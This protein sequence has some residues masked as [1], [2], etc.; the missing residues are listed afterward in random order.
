MTGRIFINGID[1]QAAYGL[2]LRDNAYAEFDKKP[3]KKYEYTRVWP[4]QNGTQRFPLTS[5]KF[6]SR[7]LSIPVQIKGAN[8]ADYFAKNNA[9]DA[10]VIRYGG[11]CRVVVEDTGAIYYLLYD[12]ISSQQQVLDPSNGREVIMNLNLEMI[13]D[14]FTPDLTGAVV[15]YGPA[16]SIPS[17]A[18]Q[19]LSLNAIPNSS[20]VLLE[21]GT[22]ATV[23][24]LGVPDGVSLSSVTDTSVTFGDMTSLWSL[25]DTINVSGQLTK[26]YAMEVSVPY[27]ESH[28]FLLTTI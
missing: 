21:T 9:F 24:V 3:K 5:P 14:Y 1:A 28:E 10:Q 19:V 15:Y 26:I 18:G 8:D 6:E 22:S 16:P 13:D 12:N 23:F 27:T 11:Y 2:C 20:P 25:R 7:S 4:D 17:N